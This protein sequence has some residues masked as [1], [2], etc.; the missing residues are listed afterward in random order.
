MLKVGEFAE[1]TIEAKRKWNDTG[2]ELV[3]GHEYV[4]T[5]S[6]QWTDWGTVCDADG[7][8]SLN[9]VLKA[10]EWLRRSPGSRWFTLIGAL[11]AN[12]LTQFEIG[13]GRQI[14]CPQVGFFPVLPTMFPGCI[15]T[16]P[17]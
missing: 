11:H 17:A 8:D 4:L 10:T 16:T 9:R 13:T 14:T 1:A 6:G 3:S 15:G 5:A 12:K 7:Y 2:I